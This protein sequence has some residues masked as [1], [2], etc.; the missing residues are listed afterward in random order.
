MKVT[1]RERKLIFVGIAVAAAVSIF[2]LITLLLPSSD[3][4][5]QE[6]DLKRKMLLRE[7]ETLS[8]E[9]TYKNRV[10]QY[11]KHLEEDRV[12]LLPGDNPNVAGAELQKL[13]MD[14]AEQS[15]VEITRKNTLPEKKMQDVLTKVAVSIETNCNLDQ[16]VHFLTAIENY[17]KFLKIEEFQINSFQ[18]QKVYQ[19][20]PTLTVVG[21]ISAQESETVEKSP[22]AGTAA[23]RPPQH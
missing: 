5:A 13:L 18:T 15:G 2:Y 17:E 4:L 11:G 20:R 23:G 22:V 12:R 3:S 21:Y 10:E 14:F 9:E 1:A 8:Y 6:V 7:R 16:L 19:I